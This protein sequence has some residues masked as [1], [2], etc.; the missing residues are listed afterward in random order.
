MAITIDKFR[1]Y[2]SA[3]AGVYLPE[4]NEQAFLD[5]IE[6]EIEKNKFI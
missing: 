5:E 2:S 3:V 6:R 1:N 4:A